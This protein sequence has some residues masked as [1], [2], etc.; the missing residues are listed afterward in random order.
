MESIDY[1]QI[2]GVCPWEKHGAMRVQ[3]FNVVIEFCDYNYESIL[4][5]DRWLCMAAKG[6]ERERERER[7]YD[8]Y[9]FIVVWPSS[10][11]SL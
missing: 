6:D 7:A 3:Q 5:L 2:F 9:P 8:G 11:N 10:I 4:P 1:K